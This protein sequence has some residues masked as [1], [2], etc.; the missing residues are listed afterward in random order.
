[1]RF[2]DLMQT[3]LAADD[4][5]GL[6]AVTLWRQ[7]VDLLAQHVPTEAFAKPVTQQPRQIQHL[8]LLEAA[9]IGPV[10]TQPLVPGQR[11]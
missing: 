10:L 1:M 4:R 6:G 3:V 8:E 5:A 9:V 7:C 11:R 2:N